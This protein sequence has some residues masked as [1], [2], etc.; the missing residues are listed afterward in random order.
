MIGCSEELPNVMPRNV[1]L[2]PREHGLVPDGENHY[3]DTSIGVRKGDIDELRYEDYAFVRITAKW[4]CANEN[5]VRKVLKSSIA[6]C[7]GNF[8]DAYRLHTLHQIDFY[9]NA[10]IP[11]S[12]RTFRPRFI[13]FLIYTGASLRKRGDLWGSPEYGVVLPASQVFSDEQTVKDMIKNAK[14]FAQP[15]VSLPPSEPDAK[16]KLW[17]DVIFRVIEEFE[18]ENSDPPTAAL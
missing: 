11:I 7:R 17:R 2:T 16:P 12:E 15:L 4:R 3:S 1:W 6:Q 10:K 14:L 5:G 18:R 8:A 13:V 9:T